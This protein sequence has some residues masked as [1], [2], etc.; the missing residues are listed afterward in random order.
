MINIGF[1]TG[2]S[3]GLNVITTVFRRGRQESQGGMRR[4]DDI[5]KKLQHYEEWFTHWGTHQ[6]L[7]AGKDEEKSSPPHHPKGTS[8]ERTWT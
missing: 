4:D 3:K 2:K 7:E 6:T 1:S 8:P 5:S